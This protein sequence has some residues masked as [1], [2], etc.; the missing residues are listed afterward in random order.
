MKPMRNVFIEA[1]I[2]INCGKRQTTFQPLGHD[3]TLQEFTVQ[4]FNRR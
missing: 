1:V 4:S 2:L 3:T